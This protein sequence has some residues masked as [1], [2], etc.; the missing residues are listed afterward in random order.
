ME[1]KPEGSEAGVRVGVEEEEEEEE[2]WG[3]HYSYSIP[4]EP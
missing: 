2:E 4:N 1:E 3:I